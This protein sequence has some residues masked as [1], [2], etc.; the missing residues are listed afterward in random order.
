[1][2]ISA[3]P[4]Q[5][6]E[7]IEALDVLRGFALFGVL[8]VNIVVFTYTIWDTIEGTNPL[9][10]PGLLP[11]VAE[12]LTIWSVVV[13]GVGKFLTIF[14]IL[15]G[16]GFYMFAKKSYFRGGDTRTL[17][18]RRLLVLFLF[19][20]LNLLLVWHGDIL[21]VYAITGLFLIHFQHMSTSRLKLWIFGLLT[22]STLI[23]LASAV[24]NGYADSEAGSTALAE[25]MAMGRGTYTQGN[26]WEVVMF[27]LQ[28]EV[29]ILI[30]NVL[31]LIPKGLGLFLIG[32]YAGKLGILENPMKH[33]TLIW[34]G[35]AVGGAV[36]LTCTILYVSLQ[37]NSLG[38]DVVATAGLV[39]VLKEI[40]TI[41]AAIFYMTSI[42][43]ALNVPTLRRALSPLAAPGR[44]AL[45]NYLVQCV[46]C[47]LLFYGYGLGLRNSFNMVYVPVLTL[48]IFT[49]QV[50]FS[51]WWL[52]SH[53]HG[54]LEWI[55]RRLTYG[56]VVQ[57]RRSSVV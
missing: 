22:L 6:A 21:H 50:F 46:T 1:M 41:F 9:L 18:Q 2:Q 15:F 51:K 28:H 19:G 57:S 52:T 54:P 3:R 30:A 53:A 29:P 55:W 24:L 35:W 34:R 7:R 56:D 47:S 17:F 43:L 33:R 36:G 13:L 14:S 27:R 12:Q 37:H 10:K 25:L 16:L 5:T 31:F 8:L 49:M 26:Y 39:S 38:M 40:G 4:T 20:I 44:M 45:T 48:V 32:V 42:M 11:T 23:F